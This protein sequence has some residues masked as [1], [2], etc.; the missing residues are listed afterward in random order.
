VFEDFSGIVKGRVE[1]GSDNSA[2]VEENWTDKVVLT[3]GSDCTGTFDVTLYT[4]YM[5][6]AEANIQISGGKFTSDFVKK[7]VAA[8]YTV[9]E[10]TDGENTIYTVVPVSE[11][12][13]AAQ[14]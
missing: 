14:A 5:K 8:G 1:Y 10:S 6:N 9:E 2:S 7:Y 11:E 13:E 4:Y 3:I 12:G